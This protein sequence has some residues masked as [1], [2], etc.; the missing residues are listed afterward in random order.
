MK[1]L[2]NENPIET[3]VNL[4]V[5]VEHWHD[6]VVLVVM[7]QL[8]DVP[9]SI[10]QAWDSDEDLEPFQELVFQTMIS[11]AKTIYAYIDSFFGE[12]VFFTHDEEG[13]KCFAELS[14]LGAIGIETIEPKTPNLE[15]VG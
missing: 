6:G 15:L 2:N 9:I 12:N 13:D 5:A 14:S 10:V 7:T 11:N 4:S 1:L 3:F 8:H